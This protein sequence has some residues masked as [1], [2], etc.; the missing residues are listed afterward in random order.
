MTVSIASCRPG[1]TGSGKIIK[2]TR[3]VAEFTSLNVSGSINVNLKMGANISVVIEADDNIMPKVISKISGNNLSLKLQGV[4]SLTNATINVEVTVP[5]LS[6]ITTSAAAK[7]SG[8]DIII[9]AEKIAFSASSASRIQVAVDAPTIIA[10]GSSAANITLTGRTKNLTA[11]SSS[12]SNVNLF[13]LHAENATASASSGAKISL[14]ASV[15]INANAS[16]AGNI[17][18]KGGATSVVKNVSSAGSISPE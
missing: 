3:Q 16:S 7:V 1:I 12:A 5:T 10:G 6:K 15:G 18:Y 4:N 11:E 14:F 9:N 17:R 13:A 2:E 8:T